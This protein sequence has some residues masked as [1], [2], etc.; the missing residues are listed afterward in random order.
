MPSL[1]SREQNKYHK[2]LYIGN[3]STGKTGSLV[4]LVEAGYSLRILDFDNGIGTLAQ[5]IKH[6]CPDKL[7]NVSYI[8]LRDKFKASAAGIVAAGAP[9][10]FKNCLQSLEKWDDG[11]IP[12]EWGPKT[13]LVLDTLTTLSQAAYTW[14]DALNPG[15]KDKRQVF[16]A[17]QQAIESVLMNLTAETFPVHVIVISHVTYNE[18]ETKGYASALGKAMG[19][20]IP[21]HFNNLILAESSGSGD[22]VKRVIRTSPTGVVDLKTEAPFKLTKTL[23]L[24]TGMATLFEILSNTGT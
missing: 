7:R 8:P 16:Y 24:E 21:R 23:P 15:V 17:A 22:N 3:S 18:E 9:V 4:S 5:F 12:S 20:K 14:F 2:I 10:A 19:P 6:R 13:I 1:E 11:S